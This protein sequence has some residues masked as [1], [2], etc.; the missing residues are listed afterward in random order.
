[1]YG[2]SPRA[3]LASR[4]RATHAAYGAPRPPPPAERRTPRPPAPRRGG[5]LGDDGG[6]GGGG[7]GGQ[8]Y[9]EAQFGGALETSSTHRQP[10]AAGYGT[11]EPRVWVPSADS[12]AYLHYKHYV[13]RR[14]AGMGSRG[15]APA[16]PTPRLPPIPGALADGDDPVRSLLQSRQERL[17][18]AEPSS[19]RGA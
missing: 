15:G 5:W 17:P 12:L 2:L 14:R 10:L 9:G 4:L 16:P 11:D 7:G 18:L 1:M 3:P 8:R 19:A 6:G 13:H